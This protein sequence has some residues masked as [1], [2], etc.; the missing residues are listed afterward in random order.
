MNDTYQGRR[1]GDEAR[2]IAGKKSADLRV[3]FGLKTAIFFAK[4]SYIHDV[5][6]KDYL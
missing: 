4:E 2:Q 6:N 1:R 3:L 5:L